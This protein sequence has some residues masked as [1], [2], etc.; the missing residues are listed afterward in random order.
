MVWENYAIVII[1]V[2]QLVECS[3]CGEKFKEGNTIHVCVVCEELIC[4][5]CIESH[6]CLKDRLDE[7][8]KEGCVECGE[9]EGDLF[10]CSEC[11][12]VIC[13]TC[14]EDHTKNHINFEVWD[15]SEYISKKTAEEL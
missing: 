6:N 2:I 7:F 11:E 1:Q 4:C 9:T 8:E 12:D 5:Q 15:A 14:I 13:E 10:E 3:E